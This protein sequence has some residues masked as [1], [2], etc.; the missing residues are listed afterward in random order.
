MLGTLTYFSDFFVPKNTVVFVN[1]HYFNFS[2]ELWTEPEKFNPNRFL[3]SAG[4]LVKPSYFIPFSLGR[5]TCIGSKMVQL[6]S[7]SLTATVLRQYRVGCDIDSVPLGMLALPPEPTM[8]KL[9]P[10]LGE[11]SDLLASPE[12]DQMPSGLAPSP[13]HPALSMLVSSSNS[14]GTSSSSGI[15]TD[16]FDS[17]SSSDP[18]A[19]QDVVSYFLAPSFSA[20]CTT[21]ST[22]KMYL[23]SS[24]DIYHQQPPM[25]SQKKRHISSQQ[26]ANGSGSTATVSGT[27]CSGLARTNS[28]CS[29]AH[30]ATSSRHRHC[31]SR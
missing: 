26:A 3:D 24:Q 16:Y 5:R 31:S 13:S 30:L 23:Q 14:S 12:C 20:S 15:N 2:P 1:N 11:K 8:F 4:K 28:V 27:S 22:T 29:L 18:S 6:V 19:D 21:A 10:R 7:T 17:S 9:T 25:I